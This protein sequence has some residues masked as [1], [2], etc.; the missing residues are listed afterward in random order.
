MQ[1]LIKS[2]CTAWETINKNIRQVTK[3]RKYFKLK[4]LFS[5]VINNNFIK[6]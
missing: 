1:R 2:T 6:Y 4:T 5:L 3:E